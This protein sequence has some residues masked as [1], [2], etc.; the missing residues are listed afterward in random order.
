MKR[1][2]PP[3]PPGIPRGEEGRLIVSL[4]RRTGQAFGRRGQR[5]NLGFGQCHCP[6]SLL[7]CV[8]R[9]TATAKA[10]CERRLLDQCAARR[11]G[12]DRRPMW[13]TAQDEL[14]RRVRLRRMAETR[15]RFACPLRSGR[16][17]LRLEEALSIRQ[18]LGVHRRTRKLTSAIPAHRSL[19][20]IALTACR[21]PSA[22][23][24]DRPP[25]SPCPMAGITCSN[26]TVS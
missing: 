24:P 21:P 20:P 1:G 18:P 2:G 10:M 9:Q 26:T 17:R 12:A 3:V 13:R 22:S 16:F 8:H 6:G 4:V 7:V 15:H 5:H 25:C 11:A 14:G 23:G 19:M